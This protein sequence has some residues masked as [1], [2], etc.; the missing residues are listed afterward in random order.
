MLEVSWECL[1]GVLRVSEVC[2]DSVRRVSW[3]FSLAEN[4]ASF[5]LQDGA[6]K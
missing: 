4:R 1:E 5:S 2:L 6:M 3:I